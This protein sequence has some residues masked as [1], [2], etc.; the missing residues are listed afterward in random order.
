MDE[1]CLF[2]HLFLQENVKMWPKALFVVCRK[3]SQNAGI[4]HRGSA[5]FKIDCEC[6]VRWSGLLRKAAD[7]L[8]GRNR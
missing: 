7:R 3:Q 6:F 1:Q 2:A 4:A 8:M 5:I